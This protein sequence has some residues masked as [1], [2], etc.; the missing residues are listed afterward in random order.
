[1]KEYYNFQRVMS[2]NWENVFFTCVFCEVYKYI[3]D[4]I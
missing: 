4:I 2:E 3:V 1:M